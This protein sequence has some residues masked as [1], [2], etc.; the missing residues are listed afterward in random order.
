MV[1]KVLSSNS[2][3]SIKRMELRF[4]EIEDLKQKADEIKHV[5]QQV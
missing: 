2:Q 4:A 1:D 3:D 5:K